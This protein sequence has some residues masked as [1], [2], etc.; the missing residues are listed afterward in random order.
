MVSGVRLA[1]RDGTGA[2]S[3]CETPV[4]GKGVDVEEFTSLETEAAPNCFVNSPG[5]RTAGGLTGVA[6]AAGA[7]LSGLNSRV[8]SLGG[9]VSPFGIGAAS[10]SREFRLS[11]AGGGRL[12]RSSQLDSVS[13]S[14]KGQLTTKGIESCSAASM[15]SL[16]SASG[17]ARIR[18]N[19]E[20]F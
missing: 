2:T 12:A 14:G 19:K 16:R 9:D 17:K 11:E 5:S 20:T 15:K 13:N 3:G 4:G 6:A 8:Y 7:K 18:S 10:G 1:Y